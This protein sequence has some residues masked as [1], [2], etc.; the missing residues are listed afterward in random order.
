MP[1]YTGD[2]ERVGEALLGLGIVAGAVRTAW[3]WAFPKPPLNG[4]GAIPLQP[5]LSTLTL[6]VS[7][8]STKVDG[9]DT[10]LDQLGEKVAGLAGKFEGYLEA[11]H[12]GDK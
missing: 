1:D 6:Q 10:K 11:R 2:G 3:R 5:N 7:T 9:M 12:Y 4:T 8:L